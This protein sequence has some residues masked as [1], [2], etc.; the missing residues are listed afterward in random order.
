MS[1]VLIQG[2][3]DNHRNLAVLYR[4]LVNT[5]PPG[6][7]IPGHEAGSKVRKRAVFVHVLVI[8]EKVQA[9]FNC[10]GRWKWSESPRWGCWCCCCC[11]YYQSNEL[12]TALPWLS[13]CLININMYYGL[14]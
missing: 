3:A 11:R 9:L 2:T 4:I 10:R 1:I 6:W 5:G 13:T 8:R 7:R 14:L 12:M